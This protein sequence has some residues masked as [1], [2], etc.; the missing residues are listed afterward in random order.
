MSQH[1]LL[2]GKT[3][4]QA[5]CDM[6]WQAPAYATA[7]VKPQKRSDEQ[8]AK[9]WSML[10]DISRAKPQGRTHIPEVWKCLFMAACGHQVAF[11]VGLDGRPFPIGFQ[12]SRLSKAEMMDL[13]TFIQAWGDE[14]G[15]RWS[16]EAAA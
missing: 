14:N 4:R 6:I 1:F 15:V 8:N 13:I 10:S 11:E 7:T 16:N 2:I 5:A 3:S 9:M 12:S